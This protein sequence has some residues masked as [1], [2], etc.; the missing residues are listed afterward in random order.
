MNKDF[1]PH[2]KPP[3]RTKRPRIPLKRSPINY[4]RRPTGEAEVFR[5]IWSEREHK[6]DNCKLPLPEPALAIYFA[7]DK[8]KQKSP[9]L[10]LEK[11]NI[12]LHCI[13][14]HRLKDHGTAQDYNKRK[15]MYA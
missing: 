1:N 6:C 3:K 15:D 8:S 10:R 12:F 14:C 9:E 4:V 13:I 7:H 2:P 11:S 5:Q